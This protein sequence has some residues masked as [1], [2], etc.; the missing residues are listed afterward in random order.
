[1][2]KYTQNNSKCMPATDTD[3]RVVTINNVMRVAE[4]GWQQS[5]LKYRGYSIITL[6]KYWGEPC[7]PILT[8]YHRLPAKQYEK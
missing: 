6:Q 8:I 5:N 3:I 7:P 1:M 4:R 2:N